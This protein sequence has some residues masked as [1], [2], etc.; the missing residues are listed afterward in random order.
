VNLEDGILNYYSVPTTT[1]TTTTA[2]AAII[3]AGWLFAQ[4]PAKFCF[5]VRLVLYP[6][7]GGDRLLRNILSHTGYTAAFITNVV[8]M[9]NLTSLGRL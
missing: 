6:E 4:P 2:A 1:T 5:L 8:R 9:S 3:L 7:D